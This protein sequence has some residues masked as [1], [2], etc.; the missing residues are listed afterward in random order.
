[1]NI[2]NNHKV[3]KGC[4]FSS[5]HY[6]A[7][8]NQPCLS[9]RL[10]AKRYQLVCEACDKEDSYLFG[11]SQSYTIDTNLKAYFRIPGL[12]N[13]REIKSLIKLRQ[14]YPEIF[15]PNNVIIG[16]YDA[17]PGALWNG[18]QPNFDNKTYSYE[19]IEQIK[20]ELESLNLSLNLTWNNNL[21][22]EDDIHDKFCNIITSIF[23]T[24]KHSITVSSKDL[25]LYL[26]KTYPNYTYYLS[27]IA[28]DNYSL[29]KYDL[30]LGLDK[31]VLNRKLNNNWEILD[32]VPFDDRSKIEFICNDFCTP[33]CNRVHHYN[34]GNKLLLERKNPI[35]PVLD[36]CSLD[37]DFIN[38]NNDHWPITIKPED[39]ENYLQKGFCNF[40]LCSR[41]DLTPILLLKI[42]PYFI[43][44]DYLLD[45]FSWVY[46][47]YE[48]TEDEAKIM[49]G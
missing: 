15:Y 27:A 18:R 39:I 6:C 36:Y 11:L 34:L 37:Y 22:T 8:F 29:S 16:I 5:F 9:V 17:F 44:P 20:N 43:K 33:F 23:H 26:K 1:M 48:I 42:L 24:G 7:K 19:E 21:I 35:N 38:F 31:Y 10:N 14:Y 45:A 49:G 2:V 47:K 12:K 3:C 13:L 28:T 46:N 41:G 4:K 30:N 40:K 32:Q 25:Y